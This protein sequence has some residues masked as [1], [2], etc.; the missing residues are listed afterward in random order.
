MPPP[1]G[2]SGA[3][4]GERPVETD[5]TFATAVLVAAFLVVGARTGAFGGFDGNLRAGAF[6][7]GAFVA[8]ASTTEGAGLSSGGANR[9]VV[10]VVWLTA[11]AA[12]AAPGR[13]AAERPP[14]PRRAGEGASRSGS[15]GQ[16]YQR[17]FRSGFITIRERSTRHPGVFHR[18][19]GRI[20]RAQRSVLHNGRVVNS[21]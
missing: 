7:A 20:G 10:A 19:L 13:A 6:V 21:G 17:G 4:C 8:G 12:R 11:D 16:P 5:E 9:D 18:P 15:T 3:S 1:A 2:R 14:G